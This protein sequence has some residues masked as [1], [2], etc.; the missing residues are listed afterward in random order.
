MLNRRFL[1]DLIEFV[2]RK[3]VQALDSVETEKAFLLVFSLQNR[4]SIAN[5]L[6]ENQGKTA[7]VEQFFEFMSRTFFSARGKA[8]H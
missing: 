1:A 4:I 5:F 2:F 8:H 7:L 6:Q 3:P